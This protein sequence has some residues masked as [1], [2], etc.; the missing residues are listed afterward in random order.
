[1]ISLR[2]M[3]WETHRAHIGDM[4]NAYKIESEYLM[5]RDDSR[6]PGVDGRIMLEC[7][8]YKLSVRM[9]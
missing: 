5:S 9:C 2:M 1:M 6:N 7:I 8:L 3:K 4:R